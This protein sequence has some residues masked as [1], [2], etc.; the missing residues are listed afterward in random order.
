MGLLKCFC[1]VEAKEDLN[2]IGK[3][4]EKIP[5]SLIAQVNSV[6]CK[7]LE[8]QRSKQSTYM[9]LTSAQRFSIGKRGAENG[10]TA[11]LR[12]YAKAFPDLSL[13]DTTV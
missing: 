12:Y 9:G 2:P 8:Q 6:V 3:L 13:K 4:S 7:R 1:P 10:V 5:S 11:T